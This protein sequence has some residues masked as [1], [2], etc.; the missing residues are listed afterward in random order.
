MEKEKKTEKELSSKKNFEIEK[1]YENICDLEEEI[2]GFIEIYIKKND[3]G[4]FEFFIAYEITKEAEKRFFDLRKKILSNILIKE[5]IPKRLKHHRLKSLFESLNIDDYYQNVLFDD[6]D[7]EEI[8]PKIKLKIKKDIKNEFV[9]I[10]EHLEFEIDNLYNLESIIVESVP[11]DIKKY[12]FDI[13]YLKHLNSNLLVVSSIRNVIQ[14][15]IRKYTSI[16]P[17]DLVKEI[18]EWYNQNHKKFKKM[19]VELETIQLLRT[20]GN[21]G[22]HPDMSVEIT[23][24]DSEFAFDNF[25]KIINAFFAIEKYNRKKSFDSVFSEISSKFKRKNNNK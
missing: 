21:F 19:D 16:E 24:N 17:N 15:I 3:D 14:L 5:K 9:P 6:N 25:I 1:L 11:E 7:Y 12:V 18:N 22:V 13:L 8:A 4:F 23:H 10:K 20:I 2:C